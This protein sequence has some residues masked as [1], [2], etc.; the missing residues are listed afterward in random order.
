MRWS[1]MAAV[2][3]TASAFAEPGA[4][5]WYAVIDGKAVAPPAIASEMGDP[6]VVEKI[7]EEGRARNQVMR[8]LTHLTKE[9]GPRLTGSTNAREA[10]RWTR[11]RF[12][13]FGLS[14]AREEPWGV[15]PFAFDRGPS[16][17]KLLVTREA[18]N[19]DGTAKVDT[20][21]LRELAFTTPA[22][23]R[24]TSGPVRGRV[25]KE[26][27]TPEELEAARESLKGAW[28][29]I[30]AKKP[31][32]Q[33]GIRDTVSTRIKAREEARKKVGEGKDPA[34]LSMTE[35]VAL[36]PVA[37]FVSASSD[38]RVWTGPLSGWREMAIDAVPTQVEVVVS[39]PDYDAI[40]SRL[41]DHE[42]IELEFDLSHRLFTEPGGVPV[43]NTIAEIV[44]TELPDEVVIVSAHLDSWNG[45]G[46]EGCTDNG[47]GSAVTLEAARILAAVG[48]KPRR[49]IRF[50]LWTGEEQGLL[51]SKAYVEANK[52]SLEKISCV[53][54]DD[55]GTNF[56]GGLQCVAAMADMLAGATAPVNG[57]FLDDVTGKPLLVNVRV[58]EKMPRGGGSDHASFNAAGVPGFF[59]DEVGRATYGRG[60][61][62]QF[63]TLDLAVPRYLEQASTCSAVT[64]YRLACAPTLLPR[65]PKD[66]PKPSEEPSTPPEGQTA[67]APG[68]AKEPGA[69]GPNAKRPAEPTPTGGGR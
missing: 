47:T 41:F 67:K 61:H 60:W 1:A 52:A 25:V 4:G 8:H 28:V 69:D 68:D 38:D 63:D 55:G 44:G 40:N 3:W 64:A 66:E 49:T 19:E 16:T 46:S 12:E 15:I 32:G 42:P 27:A 23:T 36:E 29:L 20:E 30:Q 33:R 45:P 39:R 11:E 6:A 51:G 53:F 22:W 14:N 18:K 26:P 58:L 59:W 57:A 9:I 54:V 48:A 34:E 50:I 31:V 13:A 2:A 37:G 35:R 17:A 56:Q 7:L 21:T 5:T 24:G 65:A 43:H 62:T 10:V